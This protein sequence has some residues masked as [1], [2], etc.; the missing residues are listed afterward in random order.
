M[1]LNDAKW[2]M[3]I[4]VMLESLRPFRAHLFKDGLARFATERYAAP[5]PDNL[6][7]SMVHLTNYSLNKKSS[8]FRM[9]KQ[10]AVSEEECHK[11]TI[12]TTLRQLQ[13]AG[14]PVDVEVRC[15][16]SGTACARRVTMRLDSTSGRRSAPSSAR[17]WW[18]CGPSCRTRTRPTSRRSG[19]PLARRTTRP[20]STSS[21]SIS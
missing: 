13:E 6:G 20:A 8:R 1:L 17:R 4:Y 21:G 12:S 2:D 5:R 9:F 15:R 16:V 7:Q 3:R 14:H 19:R 11:R 18:P 10:G